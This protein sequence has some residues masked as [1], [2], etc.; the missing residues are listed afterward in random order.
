MIRNDMK[1]TVPRRGPAFTL[2]ELL[3]VIAIIAILAAMLLPALNRAKRQALI[4]KAQSEIALIV[5]AIKA[6]DA[7]YSRFPVSTNAQTSV[8]ASGDDFTYGTEG[9]TSIKLP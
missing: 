3:V 5:G 1:R 4:K 9:T 7:E 2:I 6:Y 8:L